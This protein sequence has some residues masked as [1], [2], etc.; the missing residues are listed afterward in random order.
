MFGSNDMYMGY[1]KGDMRKARHVLDEFKR[2]VNAA[3]TKADCAGSISTWLKP[4]E[5]TEETVI[6]AAATLVFEEIIKEVQKKT[7]KRAKK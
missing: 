6:A 5:E 7:N 1:Y 4:N 2:A 3:K